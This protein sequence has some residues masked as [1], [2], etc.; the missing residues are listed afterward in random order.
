MADF[1]YAQIRLQLVALADASPNLSDKG[2]RL[3]LRLLMQHL[4]WTDG[5][6][7]IDNA[8]LAE[9]M[10]CSTD[11]ISRAVASIEKS[12]LLCVTRGRWGRPTHYSVSPQAWQFAAS[13]RRMIR[14]AADQ[15]E[16][17]TPQKSGISPANMRNNVPQMCGPFYSNKIKD[18]RPAETAPPAAVPSLPD[19]RPSGTA[20]AKPDAAL[21]F[22]P[23]GICFVRDWNDRLAQYGIPLL[24]R[25]KKLSRHNHRNG[26]WLPAKMPA[27]EVSPEW[28]LQ[29]RILRDQYQKCL[30]SREDRHVV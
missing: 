17:D 24:E 3:L 29:L 27:P 2:L 21:V 5:T 30:G 22:V 7:Q 16:N 11:T 26:Y 14:K 23:Q 8:T 6:C 1:S 25:W 20:Q 4:N 13:Q 12:G 28:Q 10:S 18:R 19:G 15:P 9:G